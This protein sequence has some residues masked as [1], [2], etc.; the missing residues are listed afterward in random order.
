MKSFLF[1]VLFS[2][3]LC[4]T[5]C[6]DPGENK[7]EEAGIKFNYDCI[8]YLQPAVDY[9]DIAGVSVSGIVYN[10]GLKPKK[11]WLNADL[12]HSLVKDSLYKKNKIEGKCLQ[13]ITSRRDWFYLVT[14]VKK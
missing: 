7:E 4:F 3:L 12:Y 2:T 5:G 8:F 9:D 14:Y 1:F 6:V 13:V 11:L 10:N